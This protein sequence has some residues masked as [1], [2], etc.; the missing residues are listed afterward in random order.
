M[1]TNQRHSDDHNID[2]KRVYN[3]MYLPS[4]LVQLE[5]NKNARTKE[6]KLHKPLLKIIP[7]IEHWLGLSHEFV[8]IRLC[9]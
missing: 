9:L 6:V 5:D 2:L 3:A 4:K 7:L 8:F 1:S